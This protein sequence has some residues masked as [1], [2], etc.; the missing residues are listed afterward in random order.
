MALLKSR[1][2]PRCLETGCR[3]AVPARRT[4]RRHSRWRR[5]ATPPRSARPPCSRG[6][7]HLRLGDAP[8]DLAGRF[9]SPFRPGIT[10]SIRTTSRGAASAASE[11]LAPV[12]G[13]ATTS[14]RLV[15]QQHAEGLSEGTAWSSTISTLMRL[16]CCRGAGAFVI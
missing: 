14:L 12:A 1:V 2:L 16:A 3:A 5:R 10:M 13:V 6:D 4:S 15:L 7:Q 8:A 11:R 9:R